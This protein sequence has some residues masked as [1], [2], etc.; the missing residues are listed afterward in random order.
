M[1]IAIVANSFSSSPRL[2]GT[3][4]GS[5]GIRQYQCRLYK[6]LYIQKS[7]LMVHGE[8]KQLKYECLRCQNVFQN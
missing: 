6:K 8:T 5:M 7:T 1:N 4:K 2:Y 3:L